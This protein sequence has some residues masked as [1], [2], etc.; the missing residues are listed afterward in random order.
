MQGALYLNCS[1]IDGFNYYRSTMHTC[2]CRPS[3][4]VDPDAGELTA[5]LESRSVSYGFGELDTLVS[6]YATR[7]DVLPAAQDGAT[8]QFGGAGLAPDDGL[9]LGDFSSLTVLGDDDQQSCK[10]G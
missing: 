3:E 6:A 7:D 4:K 10:I 8:Q 2:L 1:S 5:S 9:D